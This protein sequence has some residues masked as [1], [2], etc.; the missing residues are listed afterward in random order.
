[1]SKINISFDTEEKVLAVD[2]DGK[3]LKN[4]SEVSCIVYDNDAH[5]WIEIRTAEEIEGSGMWKHVRITATEEEKRM[6][7]D[8]VGEAI[9]QIT[10]E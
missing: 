4:I 7:R 3:K 10:S 9:K 1:M 6:L 8:E 2:I 5:G